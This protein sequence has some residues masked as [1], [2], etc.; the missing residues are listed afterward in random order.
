MAK[1]CSPAWMCC[2]LTTK[3]VLKHVAIER[4]GLAMFVDPSYVVWY[5]RDDASPMFSFLPPRIQHFCEAE[6][7]L[8]VFA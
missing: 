1:P 4:K 3:W 5:E 6:K 8:F 2:C 7:S